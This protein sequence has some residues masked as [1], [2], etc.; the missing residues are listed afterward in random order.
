MCFVYKYKY[1]SK[2]IILN[3]AEPSAVLKIY[4]L[5]CSQ[6]VRVFVKKKKYSQQSLSHT[7]LLHLFH[8]FFKSTDRLSLYSYLWIY[9]EMRCKM[10]LS[11]HFGHS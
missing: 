11:G 9:G 6:Q 7:E 3:E 2:F 8:Y 1:L 10:Q 5:L 4:R